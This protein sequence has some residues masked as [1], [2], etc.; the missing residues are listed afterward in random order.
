M[1]QP[2]RRN[3]CQWSHL[4]HDPGQRVTEVSEGGGWGTLSNS[5]EKELTVFWKLLPKKTQELNGS[6]SATQLINLG[7][8]VVRAQAH[9]DGGKYSRYKTERSKLKASYLGGVQQSEYN[10][11]CEEKAV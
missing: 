9:M 7:C 8:I 2:G 11:D 6:S 5:W 3:K 10:F 4:K 1:N